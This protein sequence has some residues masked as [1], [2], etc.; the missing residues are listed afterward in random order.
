MLQKFKVNS[1][2]ILIELAFF[3]FISTKIQERLCMGINY[4]AHCYCYGSLNC[5]N[6]GRL[7]SFR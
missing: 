3:F 7:P 6:K 4:K 2:Q 5:N 1:L